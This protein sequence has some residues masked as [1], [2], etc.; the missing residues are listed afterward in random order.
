[1]GEVCDSTSFRAAST[2]LKSSGLLTGTC[3]MTALLSLLT[4][5]AARWSTAMATLT[6]RNLDD[7]IRNRLRVRAALA[8][9]SMEEE[10]RVIL[11]AAVTVGD[12]AS[13]LATARAQFSGGDGIDLGLPE[14]SGDRPPPQ[15]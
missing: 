14:R 7:D 5:L 15:F 3:E 6:V 13:V 10:V 11:R 1:V 12:P 4:L 8:G 9:R 2:L